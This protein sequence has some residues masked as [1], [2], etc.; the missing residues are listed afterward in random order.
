[1]HREDAPFRHALGARGADVVLVDDLEHRGAHETA[2]HRGLDQRQHHGRRD[3]MMQQVE[4]GAVA[5]RV[6]VA[7]RQPAELDRE[8]VDGDEAEPEGRDRQRDH[9]AD[10]G[11][12]IEQR[13]AAQRAKDADPAA[14][15]HRDDSRRRHQLQRG[16]EMRGD[17]RQHRLAVAIGLAPITPHHAAEPVEILDRQRPIEAELPCDAVEILLSHL[18]GDGE[19]RE[20]A[21]G[22][23]MQDGEADSRDDHQQH[24]R[25]RQAIDDVAGHLRRSDQPETSGPIPFADVPA[26]DGGVDVGTEALQPLFYALRNEALEQRQDR[27]IVADQPLQVAISG[28]ALGEF[29]LLGA[30]GEQTIRLR[31]SV[32][33]GV[34][35]AAALGGNGA[36]AEAR[37]HIGVTAEHEVHRHQHRVELRL[38]PELAPDH[39]GRHVVDAHRSAD[40]APVLDQELLGLLADGIARRRRVGEFELDAA[41]LAHAAGAANPARGVEQRVGLGRIVFVLRQALLERP[42]LLRHEALGLR[43]QTVIERVDDRLLVDAEI[44]RLAH[45]TISE[46]AKIQVRRD[47]LYRGGRRDEDLA[48]LQRLCLLHEVRQ[49]ALQAGVVD[50]TGAELGVEHGEI[51]D[52]FED[53]AFEVRPLAMIAGVGVQ[54]DMV[55]GHALAPAKRAGPDR[56][57]VER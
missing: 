45:G 1:M 13:I 34:E 15:Q 6:P 42:G 49:D 28:L 5:N 44:E 35:A 31:A 39:R 52:V 4:E 18:P 29:E 19:L 7:R 14:E 9:G 12:R 21:A 26:I 23:Q 43:R 3:Q 41:L 51:R 50:L 48:A 37:R 40:R 54:L 24:D 33:I 38:L 8:D 46:R 22:R 30:F 57:I 16:A 27:K 53:H 55:A 17:H 25:L 32:L 11:E 20:R 56:R 36:G 10:G 47:M 2:P